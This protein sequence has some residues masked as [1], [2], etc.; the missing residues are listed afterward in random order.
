[1]QEKSL[2]KSKYK[3]QSRKILLIHITDETLIFS[4]YKELLE[5]KTKTP[6]AKIHKGYE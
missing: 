5:I 2:R 4:L 1:M 6:N 3:E